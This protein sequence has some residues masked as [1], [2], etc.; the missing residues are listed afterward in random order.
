MLKNKTA[1]ITGGSRGIGKAIAIKMAENGANVAIIYNSG[2]EKARDTLNEIEKLGVK[3]SMYKC[4]VSNFGESAETVKT[5]IND[6]GAIDVLVNNAGI[7]R[8]KLIIQM[9]EEDFDSVLDINLKGAFNMIK[10]VFSPMMK[11]RSGSII[12]VSSVSGMM[13]NPG[14]ANYSSAKAGL[15][16]LTKTVAKEIASRNVRCNAIAPGFIQ[17]DMT[18]KLSDKVKE[19]AI[20]SIPLGKM[21]NPEDIGNLAVFLASDLSGYITGEVIKI[22]GGLYI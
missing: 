20:A 18:D 11:R 13:G 2:E 12:N 10:H 8:D 21:G 5:I 9:K 15:I 6:F 17:T 19:S 16:G 22:D 3:A 4:D 14:Q 1:V 7:T